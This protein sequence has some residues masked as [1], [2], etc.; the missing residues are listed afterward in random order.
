[1]RKNIAT[2]KEMERLMKEG[3]NIIWIAPSGGRD[4]PDEAGGYVQSDFKLE[5]NFSNF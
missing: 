1:M 5:H 3:G 2:I 4:R